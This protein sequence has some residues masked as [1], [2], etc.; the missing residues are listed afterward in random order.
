MFSMKQKQKIAKAIE[1]VLLEF[2]HPEMPTERP[3]FKLFVGGKE[4]WSFA[5]IEPNWTYETEEPSINP[6]NELQ[7]NR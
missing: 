4:S 3:F 6:W 1:E 5:E 2:N 7:E